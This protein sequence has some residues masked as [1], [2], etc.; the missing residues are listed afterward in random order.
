VASPYRDIEEARATD[1][2]S[3]ELVYRPEERNDRIAA[4]RSALRLFAVPTLVGAVLG[5]L[6]TP[7]AGV[8]A[9]AVLLVGFVWW[10]RRRPRDVVVLRVHDGVLRVLPLGSRREM[11]RVRLDDLDDVVL[12]TKTVERHLDTSAAAVNIG[13]GPLTPSIAAAT[14]TKRIALESRRGAHTLTREFFGHTETTEWF[15]KIRRFLRSAGWTPRSEREGAEEDD[16]EEDADD[17]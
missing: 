16:A 3:G 11:F 15:A 9:F 4:G 14:D 13:M 8:L 1:P 7:T 17:D 6:W 2:K 10:S 5:E 12:E